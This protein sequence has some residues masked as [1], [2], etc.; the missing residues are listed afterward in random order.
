VAAQADF[1]T[2]RGSARPR[3]L[4][5]VGCT[6]SG[7]SAVALHLA[8]HLGDVEIVAVD[9]MQVYRG[10]DIGTA[11]PT[12][13]EQAEVRHHLLDLADPEDDFTVARFQQ[14]FTRALAGIEARG[15][16]ALLVAGTG[17]YLRAVVD[18]LTVPGQY[19][20]VRVTL[21]DEPDTDLMHRRLAAL[22]PV[23]AS[24][25]EPT[26]RRRIIRALEVTLGSGTPFSQHGPGLT[27]HPD[28]IR[29]DQVGL[30]LPRDVVALRIEQRYEAQMA[31]GFL[32]EVRA[33]HERPGALSR[34]ARQALGYRELLA[35]LDH[36]LS[37]GDAVAL[38]VTRT[39]QLARRQ[40][41]WFKR[42]PRIRWFGHHAE[43]LALVPALL[44]DFAR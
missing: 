32:D 36:E 21:E 10:M 33:L 8:R 22:D 7:K 38:A 17:L 43:P 25:M 29:F 28:E 9:S 15:R 41:S 37:L 35:H 40:R 6:A 2:D 18:Q 31:A 19:P 4:A 27:E 5:L 11:T 39:R 44:G 20:E 26:N 13:A 16:R 1:G 34:T 23:A 24:R 42:D 3:H 30:W 14:E 12:A